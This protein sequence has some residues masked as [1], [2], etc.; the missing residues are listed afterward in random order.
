MNTNEKL[1]IEFFLGVSFSYDSPVHSG[2]TGCHVIL[3]SEPSTLRYT[4]EMYNLTLNIH[5]V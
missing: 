5:S 1:E 4:N 3:L 2:L